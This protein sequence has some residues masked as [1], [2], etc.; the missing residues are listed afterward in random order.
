MSRRFQAGDRVRV[1]VLATDDD[2]DVLWEGFLDQ[3]GVIHAVHDEA[4][5]IPWDYEVVLDR[6]P[7]GVLDVYDR[8]LEAA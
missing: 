1:A 2:D 3:T 6:N 4:R 8:E 7:P 5:G